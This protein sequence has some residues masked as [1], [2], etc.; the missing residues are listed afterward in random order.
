[1]DE[2]KNALIEAGID[3]PN[4]SFHEEL[5]ELNFDDLSV[6]VTHY[7]S[8]ALELSINEPYDLILFGH[9]HEIEEIHLRRRLLVNPG[10]V[11]GKKGKSTY[12]IIETN[13]LQ[14]EFRE[15]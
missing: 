6:G 2:D 4:I 10:E 12:A 13:P 11:L 15:I 14:V 7:R 1:M 9:T 8:I 5:A 3:A